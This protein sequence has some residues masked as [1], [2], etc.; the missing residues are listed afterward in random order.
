MD[1]NK[2]THNETKSNVICINP[3][4][5]NCQSFPIE[6]FDFGAIPLT[7]NIKYLGIEIDS[8]F[9][10]KTH[11]GLSKVQSKISKGVGILYKLNKHLPT[12]TLITLYYALIFS[13]L[14]YGI[15]IWGSTYSSYLTSLQTL[16][17]K[18]ITALAKLKPK[19]RVTPIPIYKQYNFLKTNDMYRLE[20]AKFMHHFHSKSLPFI[21]T[22][23]F[24]YLKDCHNR[25]TRISNHTNFF[26]P[27]YS[28]SRLQRCIKYSGVRLWNCIP[29]NIKKLA[30]KN[31]VV[32]YKKV[33]TDQYK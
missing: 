6:T 28:S 22:D 26:L 24:M 23:Y 12:R 33:L 18:A 11:I 19:D 15:I 14:M 32:A 30:H 17:N 16:Q 29:E 9:N 5:R 3:K 31:F 21:F 2:L 27:Y 10:F 1:L 20:I 4:S 7:D 13:H 8:E 25:K